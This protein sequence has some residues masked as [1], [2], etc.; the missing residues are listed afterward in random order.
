MPKQDRTGVTD[1][2]NPT[3]SGTDDVV[4]VPPMWRLTT[5]SGP[6]Y[7]RDEGGRIQK[8]PEPERL[9]LPRPDVWIGRVWRDGEYLACVCES[10]DG[11]T[12]SRYHV[13][14]DDGNLNPA[15][16]AI[17]KYVQARWA[18]ERYGR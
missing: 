14:E 8:M 16:E 13:L 6:L 12:L 18:K 1:G 4:A 9:E 17:V 15:W 5:S 2:V 3:T 7:A 10:D 11:V